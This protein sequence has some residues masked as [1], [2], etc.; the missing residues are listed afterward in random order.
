M[1]GSKPVTIMVESDGHTKAMNQG[2]W[3]A[4]EHEQFVQGYK[5]HGRQW[6][7]LAEVITTRTVLQIRTHAQKYFNKLHKNS[8]KDPTTGQL[9]PAPVPRSSSSR[10][11]SPK[12]GRT[13]AKTEWD[14]KRRTATANSG[15]S[16]AT[17]STIIRITPEL[18]KAPT[19]RR[20]GKH[21]KR[22]DTSD[23]TA[24]PKR[25]KAS[26]ITLTPTKHEYDRTFD[27]EPFRF[28]VHDY[29]Y[30]EP[31]S[32]GH[33]SNSGT[34]TTPFSTPP[35]NKFNPL[36]DVSSPVSFTDL[37]FLFPQ[38]QHKLGEELEARATGSWIDE[39][40]LGD[41]SVEPYDEMYS[42]PA[43]LLTMARDPM[44]DEC[45]TE[46]DIH[47]LAKITEASPSQTSMFLAGNLWS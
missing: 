24:R 3:S 13:S 22:S 21:R 36:A 5:R 16:A 19:A 2:R 47:T 39:A 9:V 25:S 30:D 7:V 20:A 27:T 14:S 10:K 15:T 35:P 43:T 40:E 32:P 44:V 26:A 4:Q 6:K 18:A 11:S 46:L 29:Q 1:P 33:S 41:P 23:G 34:N 38:P 42:R 31:L 17:A 45:A 37:D 8:Q 12:N 28:F